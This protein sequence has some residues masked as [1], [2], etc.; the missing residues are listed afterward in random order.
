MCSY[1]ESLKQLEHFKI[2]FGVNPPDAIG[3]PDMW[4]RYQGN[5]IRKPP[6]SDP[7]DAAV[8]EREALAGRWGLVPW[9]LPA[10][11]DKIK[12]A[13]GKQQ[14][15][16]QELFF[17]PAGSDASVFTGGGMEAALPAIRSASFTLIP[18]L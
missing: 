10:Q 12:T 16:F 3:K 6:A 4:P 1:Y 15:C 11:P 9:R 2:Y 7:H 8:P 13:M 5:F 14:Y 17:A 18:K